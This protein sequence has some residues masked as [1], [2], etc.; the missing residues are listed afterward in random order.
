MLSW[1]RTVN[2]RGEPFGKVSAPK[3]LKNQSTSH[4]QQIQ[5]QPIVFWVDLWSF[6]QYQLCVIHDVRL[7]DGIVKA[8]MSLSKPGVRMLLGGSLVQVVCLTCVPPRFECV[9][10]QPHDVKICCGLPTFH[11]TT[12]ANQSALGKHAE[13]RRIHDEYLL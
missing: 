3:C 6:C 10:L 4:L 8:W 1:I 12:D 13:I 9:V 11:L 5:K 7:E 2:V